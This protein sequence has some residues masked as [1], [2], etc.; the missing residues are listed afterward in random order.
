MFVSVDP[1]TAESN[2]TE[3]NSQP[4]RN[5]AQTVAE[6]ASSIAAEPKFTAPISAAGGFDEI[7]RAAEIPEPAHGYSIMKIAEMLQ[8]ERIR[9]LPA[10]VKKNS[11]LL[12]LDAS[13]VKIEQV[14]EDAVKR[15]RALDGFERVQQKALDELETRKEGE[16]Q[17]IQAEL[18]RQVQEHNARIQA[19]KDEVAKEKERFYGWRLQKQQEEQKIADSVSYFVT[20]NPIT[21]AGVAAAPRGSQAPDKTS[22]PR[23]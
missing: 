13:G 3:E 10:E 7:Y 2:P 21:T 23:K 8:S 18:D 16:N 9:A 6:I 14:I 15:D 12:A 5:P 11:I 17:Q 20:E 22:A 1:E 19:N 4:A